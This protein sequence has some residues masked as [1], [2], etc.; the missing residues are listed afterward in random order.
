MDCGLNAGKLRTQ[1]SKKLKTIQLAV[2]DFALPAPRRGSID[3]YSGFGR[4]QQIGI[5]LHQKVQT[6]RALAFEN[7]QAEVHTSY[8]FQFKN[9]TFEV[10]GR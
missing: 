6:S 4:T 7:Y 1:M 10:S 9:H 8:E 3:I 5:E 2:T